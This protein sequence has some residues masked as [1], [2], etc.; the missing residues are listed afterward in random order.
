MP[1]LD[2]DSIDLRRLGDF[3]KLIAGHSWTLAHFDE[4][5]ESGIILRYNCSKCGKE[6]TT[7]L[8]EPSKIKGKL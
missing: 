5:G 6:W 4:L 3:E 2:D 7:M 8:L 1:C